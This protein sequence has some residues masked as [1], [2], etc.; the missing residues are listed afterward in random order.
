[1]PRH[2][3]LSDGVELYLGDCLEIVPGIDVADIAVIGDPPYGMKANTNSKR[4]SGGQSAR[5]RRT[6]DSGR[7]DRFIEGDNEPFD[8]AP[9]LAFNEVVLWGANHYAGKLPVGTTLIWLKRNPQHYGTFLSDAELGWQKGGHGVYALHAPDSPGRRAI[10]A[11]ARNPRGAPTAHPAQKPIALMAWCIKRTK[12]RRILDPY[13][14]SGTTG[15]A[16]I[17]LGR[18]FT[19]IEKD[20]KYFDTACRRIERELEQPRLEVPLD[21]SAH[22]SELYGNV[23]ENDR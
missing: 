8:P 22:K 2:E 14:G 12:G 19:G 13:M 7:D 1:M 4:F 18:K 17:Q 9:W 3:Q 15:V 5:I 23:H 11:G 21:A 10:E 20:P 6:K 16:A